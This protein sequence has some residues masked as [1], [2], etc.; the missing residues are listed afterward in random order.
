TPTPR[1][2]AGMYTPSRGK[3]Q[4]VPSR[5]ILPSSIGNNPAIADT[6]VDLPA[7][8]GPSNAVVV[9]AGASRSTSR[10]NPSG[11]R[12]TTFASRVLT[13][14]SSTGRAAPPAHRERPA[15]SPG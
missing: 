11:R 2:S 14:T 12:T 8:L 4:T 5:A 10:V 7:P 13:T 9:P 3:S 15:P 6:T 1:L